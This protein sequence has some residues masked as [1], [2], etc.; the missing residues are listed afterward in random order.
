MSLLDAGRDL[1]GQERNAHD[2]NL[3]GIINL[4]QPHPIVQ[5]LMNPLQMEPLQ[6]VMDR[7]SKTD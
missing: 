7:E 5:L 1:L 6:V 2:C 3:L 4:Q